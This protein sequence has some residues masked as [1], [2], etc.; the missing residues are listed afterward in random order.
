MGILN[1]T[2]DSFHPASRQDNLDCAIENGLKMWKQG[3]T[4]VDVGGESTRPNAEAVSLQEE[5]DRVIP[6]I[7][8]LRQANQDGLISIDT[9]RAEVARQAIAAGADMINDV[10][11]LRDSEMV[12]VVL[13]SGCAVCIMHMQGEPN[14]MQANPTYE[15]CSQE[16]SEN[17]KEIANA[18]VMAGH[19]EQ[20]ICLDP[21]IGFG[22]TLHHNMELLQDHEMFR[23]INNYS[24]LW[25]VSIISQLTGKT[26]TDDRLSGTLAIA[27]FAHNEGIDIL[28]VH[29]VEE[30]IDLL[31][32]L[33][34]L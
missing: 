19:P 24:I 30:H 2:P 11:G 17:L 20:L 31:K 33:N 27:A 21:G 28:R 4:W 26:N 23:G 7:N 6:V 22:K 13:D 16:V 12:D 29:D 32:V 5:L 1:I 34:N 14:N 3:A 18:L 8:G 10:S 15:N 25:G 9:R